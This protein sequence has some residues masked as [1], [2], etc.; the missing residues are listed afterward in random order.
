MMY[1]NSAYRTASAIALAL[2]ALAL[3]ACEV[4]R[5]GNEP[6]P[7]PT[8]S[9]PVEA[10]ATPTAT[11]TQTATSSIMREDLELDPAA[12]TP[13]EPAEPVTVTIPFPDGSD[14]SE[15][16]ERFLVDVLSSDALDEDWPVILR[17]H[18]DSGGNDQANLRASRAR[19]E[20]VAAW[21]VEYGVEDERIEVIAFGE[22]NPIAPNAL[23]DG[24]PNEEGRATN[25]R[26]EV[27]IETGKTGERR[28]SLIETL[29]ETEETPTASGDAKPLANPTQ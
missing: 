8:P 13:D 29:T 23:P 17:G 2:G 14:I 20:A 26:V 19:A 15:R 22:Q 5:D 12:E 7:E 25:R 4:R 11:P 24:S 1:D 21:L 28:P 3:S 9:E 10:T 6:A 27:T 18:T 16:A